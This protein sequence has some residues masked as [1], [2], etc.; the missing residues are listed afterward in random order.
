MKKTDTERQASHGFIHFAK[1]GNADLTEVGNIIVVIEQ[2]E[3]MK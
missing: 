1:A 2:R 3:G